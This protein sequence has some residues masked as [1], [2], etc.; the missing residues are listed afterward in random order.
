[1]PGDVLLRVGNVANEDAVESIRDAL[2][3]LGVRYE[4]VRSEPENSFPQ[5]VYFYVPGDDAENIE[6]VLG[7]LAVEHGYDAEVL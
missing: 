2:D 3:A 5:T 4:H 1:M 7:H 6:N